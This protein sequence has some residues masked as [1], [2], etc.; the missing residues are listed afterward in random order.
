MCLYPKIFKNRKYTKTKKNG[1][2][3]PPVLDKRT[4]LVPIGCGDCIEC[5]KQKARGWQ[6]RLLEDIKKHRNGVFVTFTFSNQSIAEIV[7]EI[8]RKHELEETHAPEGY[9]LDNAIAKY[10][11]RHFCEN[12]RYHHG[13]TLRHWCVT[14]LGHQGTEN[15]HLHGIVW[16]TT[17]KP[18]VK[19]L[20]K[21]VREM[22]GRTYGF[23]WTGNYV[24]GATVNYIIKYVTK[25]DD[26][27][28]LFKS[29]ILTSPGIG[30]NYMERTD[31]KNNVYKGENTVETYRSST[32]HKIAMPAY[33]RNKIYT[34]EQR[35]A[36][37]IQ[38]LD[39]NERWVCGERVSV[40][41]TDEEYYKILEYHRS[42][43]IRLG[44][45]DGAKDW[46]REV[47]ERERRIIIQKARI[48]KGKEKGI[49]EGTRT[50]D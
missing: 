43:N 40:V 12:W 11:L 30:A 2:N 41:N 13:K 14:E 9:E 32:G 48:D 21:E 39:K 10:A 24:N 4:E 45:G 36:L 23:C 1:G 5:R 26:Q 50:H 6:V 42:R 29:R 19:D 3:I 47:Y 16:P 46:D 7:G 49:R 31:W 37:W 20:V 28:K 17:N 27:H 34:E 22:W 44:Y 33:Y 15:I 18:E 25:K 38:K 8:Q 35:E